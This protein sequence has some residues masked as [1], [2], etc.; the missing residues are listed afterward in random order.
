MAGAAGAAATRSAFCAGSSRRS[1]TTCGTRTRTGA[2]EGHVRCHPRRGVVRRRAATWRAAPV[3]PRGRHG[4]DGRVTAAAMENAGFE[5]YY[6][7]QGI[8]P[9]EEWGAFMDALR[10]PLPLTF[11]INGSGHHAAALRDRLKASTREL[12]GCDRL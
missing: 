10:R 1:A 2:G 12:D 9:E 5:A 4:D 11:R 6:K 7:A 8:V 3:P